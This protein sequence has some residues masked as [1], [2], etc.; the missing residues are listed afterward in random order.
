MIDTR[1]RRAFPIFTPAQIERISAYGRQ[2]STSRGEVL[3]EAGQR[4]G[5]LYVILTGELEVIRIADGRESVIVTHTAG[6]LTGEANLLTGRPTL[7]E[8]RVK[9]PGVVIQVEHERFLDLVQADAELSQLLM[10]AFLLRHSEL[11][12][13]VF[14]DVIVLGSA[15]SSGTLRVKQFLTRN[16]HP[17]QYV[18]LDRDR[19]TQDVLDRFHVTPD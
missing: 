7:F 18:D 8:L 12:S 19:D 10:R 11:L 9:E 6:G 4:N 14:A 3:V 16:G 17:F 1:D 15:Y 2:R 5:P 13:S